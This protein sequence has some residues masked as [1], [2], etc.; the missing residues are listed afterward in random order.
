MVSIQTPLQTASKEQ[1]RKPDGG[2]RLIAV[3]SLCMAWSA[4]RIKEITFGDLRAYF[5]LHEMASRRC[6]MKKDRVPKYTLKEL[7][8]LLIH[9]GTAHVRASV[10]R[11]KLAGLLDFQT[12]DV[13]FSSDP[14][15]LAESLRQPS[16]AMIAAVTNNRRLVPVPRR[17]LRLLA[18]TSPALVATVIAHLFRCLYRRDRALASV[19]ACKASWV[20]DVFDIDIRNVK[21]ARAKLEAIKWLSVES[22]AHWRRQRYGQRVVVE[23]TWKPDTGRGGLR[24]QDASLKPT[25]ERTYMPSPNKQCLTPEMTN[26]ISPPRDRRIDPSPPRPDSH[27]ELLNGSKNQKPPESGQ[28]QTGVREQPPKKPTARKRHGCEAPSWRNLELS[29]LT[30]TARLLQ[31]YQQATQLGWVGRSESA[32]LDFVAAAEHALAKSTT[33]LPGLFR[34]LVQMRLWHHVGQNDE[35][36]AR[37]R[38]RLHREVVDTINLETGRHRQTPL[39]RGSFNAA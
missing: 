35:D 16:E 39:A 1:A 27:R 17:T 14:D 24:A 10:Q 37:I 20:A 8:E 6:A 26:P 29:D 7:A 34:H 4:Y 2:Y 25:S 30:D 23:L 9:R 5:A 31:L 19:G 36:R 33:N 22:C 13:R 11:L 18:T 3:T 32:R 15:N 12:N 38:L 28:A 21:R